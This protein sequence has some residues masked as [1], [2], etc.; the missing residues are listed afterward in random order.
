MYE[1]KH[2]GGVINWGILFLNP[3]TKYQEKQQSQQLSVL[4]GLG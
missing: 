4:V 3:T 2:A 1:N